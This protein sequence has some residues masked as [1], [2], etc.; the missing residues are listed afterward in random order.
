MHPT[1]MA[2][3]KK[4]IT[5]CS[6]GDSRAQRSLYDLLKGRMMGICL[7]YCK[8]H[9]EAQDIFQEAMIRLFKNMD[10]AL[11]VDNFEAWARRIVINRAIDY[12]NKRNADRLISLEDSEAGQFSQDD[13]TV[14]DEL[15]AGEII[16]LVRE[17]PENQMLVFNLYVV[18]G[19]A[20]KEIAEKLRIQES[21]SRTL[22]ARAKKGLVSML[23]KLEVGEREY[24]S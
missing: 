7:R 3:L 19:Y 13:V 1:T 23:Q 8:D 16:S 9:E 14:L 4:L 20:H 18:D 17:L 11:K 15:G 24:G 22:L 2:D 5:Q 6:K 10:K 12:Y 21:S